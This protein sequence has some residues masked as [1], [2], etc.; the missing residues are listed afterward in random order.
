MKYL[1]TMS[2][3][4]AEC[5]ELIINDAVNYNAMYL[6]GDAHVCSPTCSRIR[7][8]KIILVDPKLNNPIVW[9]TLPQRGFVTNKLK[10][11]QSLP[12]IDTNN[13]IINI[14]SLETIA[15]S[16][17]SSYHTKEH[18]YGYETFTFTIITL[19]IEGIINIIDV[20]IKLFY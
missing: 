8:G 15:E 10:R 2:Y 3:Q 11:T 1:K 6:C 4:C 18:D 9:Q 5:S 20:I 19:I 14:E 16:S 17:I 7:L 12:K 13:L